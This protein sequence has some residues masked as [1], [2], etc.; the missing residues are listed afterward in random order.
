MLNGIK[1]AIFD[2]DGTLINSLI[3]WDALWKMLG[4]KY[5][6]LKDFSV[7]EE[8]DKAI[9]TMTLKEAMELFKN[10]YGVKEPLDDILFTV[11][12]RVA[13]FYTNEVKVKDGVIDFL[14]ALNKKGIKMCVATAT[15]KSLVMLAVKSCGLDKYF[16]T[17]LSCNDIGKG[18]DKP[19]IYLLAMEKLSATKDE[20]CIFEDSLTAIETAKKIGLKAVGIY[21]KYNYGQDEIRRISD[22]YIAEGETLLKLL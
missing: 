16:D 7:S 9:R 6:S 18:K 11:N 20:T 17:V 22:E 13:V 15:E 8:M 2:M 10:T 19:D 12:E 14:D 21:D 3:I 1:Y 4:E 5:L